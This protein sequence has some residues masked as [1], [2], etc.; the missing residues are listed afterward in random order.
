MSQYWTACYTLPGLEHK[1]RE[2]IEDAGFGAFLPTYAKAWYRDGKLCA[3]EQP[4]LSR[5]VF[6]AMP[7]GD[8]TWGKLN[9]VDGIHRVLT[10][11]NTPIRIAECDVSRLMLA[12]ATGSED[13]VQYGDKSTKYVPIVRRKK[14]RPR[15]RSLRSLKA[16]RKKRAA[17]RNRIRAFSLMTNQ[18]V[19]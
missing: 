6:I 3:R 19:A 16:Q 18:A 15:P 17:E 5:Y 7:E 11:D 9:D 1:A 14:R 8:D 13:V 10:N 12:H 2:G 4:L